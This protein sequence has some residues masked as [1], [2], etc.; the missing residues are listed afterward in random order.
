MQKG[1][2][3]AIMLGNR[4]E[5]IPIDLAAVSLGAMPFSIYQ[6]SSPEQIQYVRLGRRA[7]GRRSSRQAFSTTFD[8]AR[9]D[10]PELERVIVVD[11]DG[12]DHT[13]DELEA[14]DPDF[15]PA[16]ASPSVGPDDLLDADLHVGHHRAAEGRPA[17]PSQ[18]DDR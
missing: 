10:L 3:V 14:L 8:E 9:K 17:H 16:D 5:F 1:D 11:G 2:T 6:T 13:L 7:Q 4:P 15:D 12:G 18:P